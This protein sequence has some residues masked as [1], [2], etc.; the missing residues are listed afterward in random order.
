MTW[1]DLIRLTSVP[2]TQSYNLGFFHLDWGLIIPHQTM[3]Y[4]DRETNESIQ[5]QQR[6][7]I[8][9]T[10]GRG[11]WQLKINKR[12]IGPRDAHMIMHVIVTN[13]TPLS[14]PPRAQGVLSQCCF[15]KC[16]WANGHIYHVYSKLNEM[17]MIS[18]ILSWFRIRRQ[19]WSTLVQWWCMPSF[20][21]IGWKM[22]KSF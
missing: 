15:M 14:T 9:R 4:R 17:C 3:S 10:I 16:I 7:Q 11:Q 6:K 8:G 18:C 19:I 12:P 5:R 20:I 21:K 2:Y 1:L 22:K 13:L